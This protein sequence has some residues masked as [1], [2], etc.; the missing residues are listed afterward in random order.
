MLSNSRGKLMYYLDDEE[1]ASSII[2]ILLVCVLSTLNRSYFEE[3][4]MLWKTM[5]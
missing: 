1:V 5:C 2:K 4:M 3:S